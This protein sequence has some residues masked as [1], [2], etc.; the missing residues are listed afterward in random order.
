VQEP[1][2]Q[3]I[4]VWIEDQ[5][6]WIQTEMLNRYGWER[7]Y[8]G[9]HP[10]GNLSTPDYQVARAK[11]RQQEAERKINEILSGFMAHINSKIDRLNESVDKVR[12]NSDDWEKVIRYLNTCPQD[13]YEEVVREGDAVIVESILRFAR[14]TRDLLF[15]WKPLL[16]VQCWQ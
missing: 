16:G 6:E 15:C 1:N 13:A 11:E 12:H 14:N 5:K 8:K 7:E 2:Q 3:G 4:I 10:W 9:S